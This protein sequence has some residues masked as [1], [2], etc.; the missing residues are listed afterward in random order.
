MNNF[1]IRLKIEKRLKE[2][3]RQLKEVKQLRRPEGNWNLLQGKAQ[4]P[5]KKVQQYFK[6]RKAREKK[7]SYR[8][9][10]CLKQLEALEK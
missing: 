7:C 10:A 8:I 9:I 3:N 2:W 6:A 1:R 5:L 4:L